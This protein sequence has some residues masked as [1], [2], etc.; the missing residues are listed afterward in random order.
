[1]RFANETLQ[2]VKYNLRVLPCIEK[3]REAVHAI[4]NTDEVLLAK[5]QELAK[6]Q[7]E[8]MAAKKA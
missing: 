2:D 5:K 7:T 4:V 8:F 1:M 3:D 6:F